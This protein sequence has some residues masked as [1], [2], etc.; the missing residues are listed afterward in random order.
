MDIKLNRR[1]AWWTEIEKNELKKMYSENKNIL[2]ISKILERTPIAIVRRLCKMKIINK[3]NEAN[4]Y[5]SWKNSEEYK[6]YK[7]ENKKWSK[8]NKVIKRTKSMCKKKKIPR[9]IYKVM[10]NIIIQLEL[11]KNIIK[12]MNEKVEEYN[13]GYIKKRNLTKEYKQWCYNN[14]SVTQIKSKDLFNYFTIKYGRYNRHRGWSNIRLI[15]DDDYD[16]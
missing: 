16:C 11:E 7:N 14:K 8:E 9:V 1:G 6:I 10:N 15:Y 4:G 2:T 12:F 3:R 5:T 13:S